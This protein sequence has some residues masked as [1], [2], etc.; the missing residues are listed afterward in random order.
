MSCLTMTGAHISITLCLIIS[1]GKQNRSSSNESPHDFRDQ[2]SARLVC[3]HPIRK[4]KVELFSS[5]A[6]I[7]SARFL[8]IPTVQNPYCNSDRDFLP[9]K[10]QPTIIS[11]GHAKL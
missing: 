1:V 8:P 11:K 9:T 6:F 3:L 4:Q 7:Q 2:Y 10:S 5:Y